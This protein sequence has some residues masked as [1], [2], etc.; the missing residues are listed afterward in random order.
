VLQQLDYVELIVVGLDVGLVEGR[1]VG[2]L[3]LGV[4][5]VV[6]GLGEEG[7]DWDAGALQDGFLQLFL[8]VLLKRCLGAR[9][10]S[11]GFLFII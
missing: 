10:R 4:D 9:R 2:L 3:G 5:L 1:S 6:G 11:G 8:L 7:V